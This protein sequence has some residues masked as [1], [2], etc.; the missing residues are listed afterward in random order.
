MARWRSWENATGESGPSLGRACRYVDPRY[1]RDPY[2][3]E[4]RHFLARLKRE[5]ALS[6]AEYVAVDTATP[7][8]IMLAKY[9]ALRGRMR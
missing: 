7:F 3:D 1:A 6:L 2:I 5:C 9:L 4:P 8:D